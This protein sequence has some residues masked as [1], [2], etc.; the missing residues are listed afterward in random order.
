MFVC[1]LFVVFSVI[2]SDILLCGRLQRDIY[3]DLSFKLSYV[4]AVSCR[5]CHDHEI[6]EGTAIED[7]D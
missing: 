7:M 2:M 5:S 4:S 1:I 6:T 3:R